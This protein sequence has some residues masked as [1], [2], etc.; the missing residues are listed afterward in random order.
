[1]QWFVNLKTAK[2][3]TGLVFVLII[4]MI[5]IGCVGY[6]SGYTMGNGMEEMY[7]D[8][9]L[10]VKWLN[11]MRANFRAVEAD[12]YQLVL[13][14]MDGAQQ[15]RLN[16]DIDKRTAETSQLLVDYQNTKL[17][18]YETERLAI[19][20][21]ELEIYRVERKAALELAAIGKNQEAYKYFEQKAVPHLNQITTLL[22]E[23][24]DYN[25]Q[26]ADELNQKGDATSNFLNKLTWGV[27]IFAIVL[28]VGIGWFI[29]R[30]IVNPLKDMLNSIAKDEN[31]N[32]TIREVAITS[33]DEVGQLGRALNAFTDQ[34]RTV[35][36]NVAGSAEQLAA[37]SE[38]LTASA[39]Q[40]AQAA[41]VVAESVTE[42][43]QGTEKQLNSIGEV[44][45]IVGQM[46]DGIQ[47]VANNANVMSAT[48]QK[49]ANATTD[50]SK[51]IELAVS[52]IANIEKT[53]ISS[54]DVVAR[55]GAR[56]KEIG[57]IVDVISGIAGQTN[58]LALNAAIEAAR[59]GEHGRGFAV[60]AEEVRKLAE[61]SQ[62]SAKQIT[63]LVGEIQG[64]T[65]KAVVAMNQGTQEVKVGTEVVST[66]GKAFGDIAALIEQVSAQIRDVSAA[67]QQMASGS[68]QVVSSVQSIEQVS[69]DAAAQ[70][71]TVSAATEEQS[72]SMEEIAASSQS[73]SRMAQEL[74]NAINNFKV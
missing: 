37:S 25:A 70:T 61:Q 55:L 53:V 23:M 16:E 73:L 22:K 6:Y 60:V 30:I 11:V 17:H 19:L 41:N 63:E 12:S 2:K 42:V 5:G 15:K 51:A 45:D 35:I 27:T 54:A 20:K 3:I 38:Q 69:K 52:Q 56:S 32:I 21:E 9:L 57:Q 43:S 48:S 40:S 68:Q 62:E 4:F 64:D 67:T 46:A 1:M 50:G 31:G 47:Q 58:L 74:Q 72:A 29:T 44:S 66:A 7:K 24:A 36:K 49:T 10:P 28:A 39:E 8:R 14:P 13:V 65:D 34:V 26:V 71:Q 18:A 33:T 59:A